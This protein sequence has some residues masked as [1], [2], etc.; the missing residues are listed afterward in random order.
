MG[1]IASDALKGAALGSEPHFEVPTAERRQLK[2]EHQSRPKVVIG[3]AWIEELPT[4]DTGVT[5]VYTAR[6]LSQIGGRPNKLELDPRLMVAAPAIVRIPWGL[7]GYCALVISSLGA[8]FIDK[9]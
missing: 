2:S 8:I 9:M 6:C 1:Y 3:S 7:L 4:P 5:P